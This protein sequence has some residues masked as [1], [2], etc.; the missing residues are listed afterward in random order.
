MKKVIIKKLFHGLASV[1]DYLVKDAISN[2]K[3][4]L[5]VLKD[6]GEEML[7]PAEEIKNKIVSISLNVFKSKHDG[8]YY[9]LIDFNWTPTIR[10]AKLI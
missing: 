6:T 7:I 9:R 4:L 3:D 1:R 2:K 8:R 10:Q 5:I